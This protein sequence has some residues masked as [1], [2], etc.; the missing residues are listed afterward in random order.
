[1]NF[2]FARDLHAPPDDSIF[3]T[4]GD[5]IYAGGAGVRSERVVIQP[6]IRQPHALAEIAL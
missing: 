2:R 1:M 6:F 5:D 4:F 3:S